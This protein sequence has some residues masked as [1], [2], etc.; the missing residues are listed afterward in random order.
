MLY[1]GRIG[2]LWGLCAKVGSS[3][4][5]EVITPFFNFF[6]T[7]LK[8]KKNQKRLNCCG[9]PTTH[10]VNTIRNSYSF[11]FLFF[12]FFIGMSVPLRMEIV[13]QMRITIPKNRPLPNK[14]ITI[15]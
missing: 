9:W 8:K 10:I 1:F 7:K 6:E 13:I 12:Y 4:G 11:Q 3:W 2:S 15:L 14:R 5:E